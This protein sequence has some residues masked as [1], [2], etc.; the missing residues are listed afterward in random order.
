GEDDQALVTV[1]TDKLIEDALNF[2]GWQH[3]AVPDTKSHVACD[4]FENVFAII[5]LQL[6]VWVI[7]VAPSQFVDEQGPEV[8][9]VDEVE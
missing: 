3:R 2:A 5:H 9:G 1:L 7:R 6:Q 4:L 8:S